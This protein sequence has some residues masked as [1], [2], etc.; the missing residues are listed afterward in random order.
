V[1]SDRPHGAGRDDDEG[2]GPTPLVASR[3]QLVEEHLGLAAYLAGRFAGRGQ[4]SEDLQQVAFLALVVAAD[5]FDPARGLEF[6]TFATWTVLGELKHHFRDHGWAVKAPRAIQELSLAV[7]AVAEDLTHQLGRAPTVAEI[8]ASCGRREDEVL[9]AMTAR[10][11]YRADSLDTTDEGAGRTSHDPVATGDEGVDALERDD[12]LS[13]HLERLPERDRTLL[14]LRFVDELN[15]TEIASRMGLSQVQ[16]SR[17]LR[18]AV[19]ALRQSYLD[20]ER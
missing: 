3:D 1:T 18:R 10:R 13:S 16:V 19:E 6:S 9:R 4:S 14:R 8:A 2:D 11:G 7:T 20:A 15:Q 5:R 12:E 17:L